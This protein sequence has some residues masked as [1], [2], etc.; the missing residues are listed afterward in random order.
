MRIPAWLI[1]PAIS[2]TLLRWNLVENVF[3]A[4]WGT[5]QLLN[6][7]EDIVEGRGS[8]RRY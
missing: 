2:L 1:L 3:P 5:K 6:I 7:L 4:A 8:A